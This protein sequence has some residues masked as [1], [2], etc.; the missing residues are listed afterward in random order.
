LGDKSREDR[1][2]NEC[3]D[4]MMKMEMK[5]RRSEGY[6]L[7]FSKL[8]TVMLGMNCLEKAQGGKNFTSMRDHMR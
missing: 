8:L 2:T 3:E 4:E 5:M 7:K 1:A 6:S